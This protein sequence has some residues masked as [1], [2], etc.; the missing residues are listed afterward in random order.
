MIL[1]HAQIAQAIAQ[2]NLVEH[3]KP[4]L[5]NAASL[6]VRLGSKILVECPPDEDDIHPIS[7]QFRDT[8]KFKTIDLS[9]RRDKTFT[10]KP[11]Q[12][13][14]ASTLEIFNLPNH[15]SAEYKLKSSMARMGLEHLNA[16]WCDA[17]WHGSVL[18]LELK[19]MTQ[20]HDIE[21]KVGDKIGQI[22]FYMHDAVMASHSYA[23]LGSYNK[24]KEASH[25]KPKEPTPP[26]QD[27]NTQTSTG[28]QT[29]SVSDSFPPWVQSSEE[30]TPVYEGDGGGD[31]GGA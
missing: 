1:N 10:L 19:N 15:I 24:D 22:I 2:F 29:N 3:H 5:L 7:L 27:T 25:A 8:P 31:G 11:G 28:T 30:H 9:K 17:G 18:T 13:I 14:L 6:D 16:G 20:Y 23:T 21:L 26:N 4:E 12:F